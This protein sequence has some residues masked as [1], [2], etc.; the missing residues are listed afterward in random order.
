MDECL[1]EQC[2][3]FQYHLPAAHDGH[4]F[5][6]FL[7]RYKLQNQ[8]KKKTWSARKFFHLI[9]PINKVIQWQFI[10]EQPKACIFPLVYNKTRKKQLKIRPENKAALRGL[11]FS[12]TF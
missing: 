7:Q 12:K 2:S 5:I 4:V 8:R 1:P 6:K 9:N 3:M 10:H 11:R